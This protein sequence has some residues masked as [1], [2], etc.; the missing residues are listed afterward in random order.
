VRVEPLDGETVAGV[1]DGLTP[2]KA[3]T[4]LIAIPRDHAL[5]RLLSFPSVDSNELSRMVELSVGAQFP[6]PPDQLVT[7]FQVVEQHDGTSTVQVVACRRATVDSLVSD[8]AS[9][10]WQPR[11]ITPASWGI[12]AWFRRASGASDVREPA[13]IVHLDTAQTDLVLMSRGRVAFSRSVRRGLAEWQAGC[14][15]LERL[16][17]EV[18]RHCLA[19]TNGWPSL[20]VASV[21]LTGVGPLEQWAEA[22]ARRV[23]KPVTVIPPPDVEDAPDGA[24]PSPIVAW[25]LGMAQEEWVVNVAP[26][27]LRRLHRRQQHL[28]QAIVTAALACVVLGLGAGVVWAAAH[29][30]GQ[31]MAQTAAVMR[32]WERAGGSLQHAQHEW[33]RLERL[34]AD[35]RWSHAMLVELF[36]L[37]PSTVTFESVTVERDPRQAVVRGSASTTAQVLEHLRLLDESGKWTQVMLRHATPRRTAAGIQTDFEILLIGG[38]S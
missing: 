28:R 6:Y 19:S 26:T 37:T 33:H 13:M 38:P 25:G 32:E 9:R 23:G 20:E 18:R 16:G 24:A 22:L 30:Q 35:R 1:L 11:L 27:E 10:G 34:L 21:V 14:D 3:G 2:E 31:I 17:H 15:G 8:V 7:D 12:G 5:T 4:L 36:R 29:R